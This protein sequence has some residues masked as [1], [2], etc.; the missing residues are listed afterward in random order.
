MQELKKKPNEIIALYTLESEISDLYVEGNIDKAIIET[1]LT[2]KKVNRKVIPID[3][4]DFSQLPIKYFNG[5]DISSNK[6]KVIVLSKLLD[7]NLPHSKVNCIVDK[8]FDD[9]IKS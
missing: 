1:F 3:V 4:I 9:F 6:S 7:D 2:N 5:L 8:D